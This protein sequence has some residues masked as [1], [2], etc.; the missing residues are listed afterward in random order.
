VLSDAECEQI[1]G[2]LADAAALADPE[3]VVIDA[4]VEHLGRL[5]PLLQ[6]VIEEVAPGPEVVRSELGDRAALIG[7]IRLARP[8]AFEG[9]RRA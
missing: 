6:R 4:A 7:A 9:Q 3:Y 8:L 2:V 1:A 5:V